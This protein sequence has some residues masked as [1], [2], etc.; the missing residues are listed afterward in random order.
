MSRK[1]P[2]IIMGQVVQGSADKGY[3]VRVK[4]Y[5]STEENVYQPDAQDMLSELDQDLDRLRR[6][7]K[8]RTHR[9]SS[10]L[11]DNNAG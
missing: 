4:Y 5:N 10:K 11:A 7:I 2:H 1:N 8:A 3:S 9:L 6:M